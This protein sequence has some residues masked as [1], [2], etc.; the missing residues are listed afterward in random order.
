MREGGIP[1]N[2]LGLATTLVKTY[3]NFNQRIDMKVASFLCIKMVN[4]IPN[5]PEVSLI[6]PKI[7]VMVH[8]G[9]DKLFK[10]GEALKVVMIGE[11][12][13]VARWDIKPAM[14]GLPLEE[15]ERGIYIGSYTVQ[16]DDRILSGQIVGYLQSKEGAQSRWIDILGH[17]YMG[18]PTPLP[19]QISEDL[20]LSSEKSPYIVKDFLMVMPQARLVIEQG[21]VILFKG[22][23]MIVRGEI[24][25]RGTKEE[26]IRFMSI[27]ANSWKGIFID[28]SDRNNIFSHCEIYDARFGIRVNVS[29]VN[30]NNCLFQNN[31]WSIVFEKG[32]AT[33]E[34][35]VI[36]ASQKVGISARES[37][38]NIRDSVISENVFG[39]ILLNS[40][41]AHIINNNIWNNGE[42]EL[43]ASELADSLKISQNWWGTQEKSK[44]RVVGPVEIKAIL[45]ES[46]RF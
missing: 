37:E 33:I 44:I 4:T 21:A 39:G 9:A 26:P 36:R 18:E 45:K 13:Q 31:I 28:N 41:K 7:E 27:D 29:K 42:W 35:S 15:K 32:T 2:P 11:P 6:A 19:L 25:V 1:T 10:P 3:I 34:K 17:V 8:N 24:E 12:G 14:K 30:I 46:I 43:K 16:P 23:G 20:V 5:P 38:I 22:L 40:T